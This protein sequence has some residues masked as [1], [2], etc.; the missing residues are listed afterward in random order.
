VAQWKFQPVRRTQYG[1]VE[2]AFN[3]E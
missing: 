2:L 3:L 1:M